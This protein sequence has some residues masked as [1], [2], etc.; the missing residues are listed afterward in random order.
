MNSEETQAGQ[1]LHNIAAWA[2]E[3]DKIV[4]HSDCKAAYI[5]SPNAQTLNVFVHD[6]RSEYIRRFTCC[7]HCR[8]AITLSANAALIT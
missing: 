8:R 1:S 3:D 2:S 5:A 6:T 4:V 7:A